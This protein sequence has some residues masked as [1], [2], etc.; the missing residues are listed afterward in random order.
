MQITIILRKCIDLIKG[1]L[2]YA[3][4][5]YK[6]MML[7]RQHA[8]LNQ[9]AS[10]NSA[11]IPHDLYEAFRSSHY[12]NL[13]QIIS[14]SNIR[15]NGWLV[16][17]NTIIYLF[18]LSK[19][20]ITPLPHAVLQATMSNMNK[21]IASALTTLNSIYGYDYTML[22]YPYLANGLYV[23]SIRDMGVD[24]EIGVIIR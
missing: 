8:V 4:N 20:C 23:Y 14:Y 12:P 22:N 17:Q 1:L 9:Q 2:E 18:T 3:I 24:I 10:Y 13:N 21:D 6:N 5:K 15:I 7:R 11:C 16:Q 19:Q